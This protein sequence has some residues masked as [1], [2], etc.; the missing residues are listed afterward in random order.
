MAESGF[1][2]DRV[3]RIVQAPGAITRIGEIAH[4]L[5]GGAPALLVADPGLA[6][7]GLIDR[8]LG[9]L[10]DAQLHAAVFSDLKSDP[11]CASIDAA[12]ALARREGAGVVVAL[13][14]GSALDVG[15]AAAAIAP[16]DRPAA[17]YALCAR[18]L[19]PRPL[20]ILAVPTTSGTGSEATR[21]AIASLPDGAK[22]WLWGDE[23]KPAETVLDPELTVPLPPDLT[24]TTGID[25]LIHALEATTNA[26]AFAANDVFCLEAIRL[27]ARHLPR[28]VAEPGD[29][30]ARAGVQLAACLAGI[31]IDNA[32][33]AIAHNIGHALAS[34]RPIHHGR[35]VGLATLATLPWN[36]AEDPDGRFAAVAEAMDAE[37]DAAA[38]P[39]A[40]E[41]LLR[42]VGIKVSLAGEGY[43]DVSADRLA[44][45]MAAP[46]NAPMRDANHR[47]VSDDDL[48]RFARRV[49]EQA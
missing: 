2:L 6:A 49:L 9:A 42:G 13:G 4:R 3:P 27:V 34:L 15:K 43:D 41:H 39:D 12:A 45:Q 48:H 8:A 19:P 5:G 32:G 33:T 22:I 7:L 35:A 30:E 11:T 29:L 40:F 23:M 10:R 44:A 1:T 14:G 28:A 25:A 47:T 18:P 37:R 16:A 20:P 31:A 17:D 21:T 26:R 38:L 36:A 46:E 24:A